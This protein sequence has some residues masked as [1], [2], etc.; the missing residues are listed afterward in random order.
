MNKQALIALIVVVGLAI[1]GGGAY[2]VHHLM[3]GQM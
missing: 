2:L 3:N 1:V